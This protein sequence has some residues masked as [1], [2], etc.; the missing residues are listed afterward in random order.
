MVM[1]GHLYVLHF[2]C[3]LD[4]FYNKLLRVCAHPCPRWFGLNVVRFT[5]TC[6]SQTNFVTCW[7]ACFKL[8]W[9]S[10]LACI[11]CSLLFLSRVYKEVQSPYPI[12]SCACAHFSTI[13]PVDLHVTSCSACQLQHHASIYMSSKGMPTVDN[14][15]RKIQ[16]LITL[17]CP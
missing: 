9:P 3:Q 15:K 16:Y 1:C 14:Q 6:V 12:S 11:M 4:S 7:I 5:I 13:Y 2:N 17:V 8:L 10:S